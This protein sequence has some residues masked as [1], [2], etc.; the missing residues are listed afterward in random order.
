MDWVYENGVAVP[1]DSAMGL[2]TGG[3]FYDTVAQGLALYGQYMNSKSAAQMNDLNYQA[4]Q[5][6]L[7]D[8]YK[9]ATP[10]TAVTAPVAATA[11]GTSLSQ[12]VLLMLGVG[13]L[14]LM[15]KL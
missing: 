8:T 6:K 1:I 12:V 13:V 4:A 14:F 10:G 15:K 9:S 5:L 11:A 7:V 3:A 2:S